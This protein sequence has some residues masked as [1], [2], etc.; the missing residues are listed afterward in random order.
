MSKKEKAEKIRFMRNQMKEFD[1]VGDVVRRDQ[2]K[3]TI[4]EAKATW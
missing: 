3:K 1:R 4:E 2:M